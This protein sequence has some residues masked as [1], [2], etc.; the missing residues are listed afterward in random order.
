[1]PSDHT[2]GETTRSPFFTVRT[3]LPT[4]SMT[5]MN[6]CPMRR[7]VSVGSI[8]LYGHRSLPQMAERVTQTSAP[9]GSTRRA[10]GT[11]ST[12]TSPAPYMRVARVAQPSTSG[13]AEYS[14]SVT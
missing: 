6:S 3:S 11:V 10:S 1:V 7:P 8:D 4:S 2:N 13:A 5:P 12:R 14:S 9:V